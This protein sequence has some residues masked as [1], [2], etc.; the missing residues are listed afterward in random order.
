MSLMKKKNNEIKSSQITHSHQANQKQKQTK[1]NGEDFSVL[2]FALRCP[3][4]FAES[5]KKCIVD[6]L[7]SSFKLLLSFL[8]FWLF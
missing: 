2:G 5:L 7:S 4:F 3:H 1:K 6:H 8:F